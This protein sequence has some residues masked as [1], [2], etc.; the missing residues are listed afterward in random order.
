MVTIE[1]F[2]TGI[3]DYIINELAS[4]TT[5]LKTWAMYMFAFTIS[6]NAKSMIDKYMNLIKSTGYMDDDGSIDESRLLSDLKKIAHETGSVR[7]NIP[8]I[9]DFTFNEDDIDILR[10]YLQ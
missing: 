6:N 2:S 9:G 5:G 4:K 1:K 8:A 10:R 3:A 7:Q